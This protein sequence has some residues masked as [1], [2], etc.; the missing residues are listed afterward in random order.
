M[1]QVFWYGLTILP[2]IYLFGW[3]PAICVGFFAFLFD[4]FLSMF[5]W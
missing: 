4:K 1:Y 5:D 3:R 2:T